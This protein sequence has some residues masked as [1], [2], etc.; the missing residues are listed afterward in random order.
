MMRLARR[1]GRYGF[2]AY[3]AW[4][5]AEFA[6]AWPIIRAALATYAAQ[7]ASAGHVWAGVGQSLARLLGFA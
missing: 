4:T 5:V 7:W 6:I 1:F 2:A 3:V